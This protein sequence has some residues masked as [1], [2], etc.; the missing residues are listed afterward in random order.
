MNGNLERN[1]RREES[2]RNGFE[3]FGIYRTCS[4]Y[5]YILY[6]INP[7]PT[8]SLTQTLANVSNHV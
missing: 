1:E 8:G 5:A 6:E 3:D 4:S 2:G 7:H